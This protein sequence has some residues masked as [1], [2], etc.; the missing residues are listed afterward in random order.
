MITITLHVFEPNHDY[1]Y[2]WL[3]WKLYLI[4]NNYNYRLWLPQVWYIQGDNK[5]LTKRNEIS[6]K[7]WAN[8][9]LSGNLKP[10]SKLKMPSERSEWGKILCIIMCGICLF[11]FKWQAIICQFR[12][13]IGGGGGG[14]GYSA[15]TKLLG[16][17]GRANSYAYVVVSTCTLHTLFV[18]FTIWT[19]N[20]Q[21]IQWCNFVMDP[22]CLWKQHRFR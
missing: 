16:G 14:K 22:L 6:I 15:P 8:C 5:L 18:D 9:L 21:L 4:T 12:Q 17:G 11:Y 19:S 2:I 13:I 1:N 3:L 7:L 10:N 20:F